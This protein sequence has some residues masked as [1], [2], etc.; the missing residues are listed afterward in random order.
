MGCPSN[1]LVVEDGAIVCTWRDCP[2]PGAVTA[3]LNT[4][5]EH[6]VDIGE[7]GFDVQHPLRERLD[8][9][10]FRCP[11]TESLLAQSEPP[12][13]PGVYRASLI[14]GRWDFTKAD[15]GA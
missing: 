12:C 15:E 3:L 2:N 14:D 5:T 8:G 4:D 6:L 9:V 13:P 11:L 1:S 7:T 10:L